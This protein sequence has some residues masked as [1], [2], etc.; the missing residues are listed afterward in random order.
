MSTVTLIS[1]CRPHSFASTFANHWSYSG[2]K[3]AHLAILSVC[4]LARAWGEK[5]KNGP[6]AAAP[7]ANFRKSRRE[8]L[9]PVLL[10]IEGSVF[11]DEQFIEQELEN[12]LAGLDSQG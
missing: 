12:P 2:R 3:W 1:F 9:T 4:W 8:A 6:S 7:A 11:A 5:R 10:V